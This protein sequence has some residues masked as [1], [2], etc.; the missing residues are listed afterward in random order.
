MVFRRKKWAYSSKSEPFE[1]GGNCLLQGPLGSMVS[2][3]LYCV[4]CGDT[5]VLLRDVDV[6]R[7]GHLRA[8][9]AIRVPWSAVESKWRGTN[10]EG[11]AL[12]LTLR[13]P[14]APHHD[15]LVFTDSGA[16]LDQW[17]AL[18]NTHGVSSAE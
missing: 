3:N 15:A 13:E 8:R 4:S 1:H 11:D 12:I 17:E 16:A 9:H 7:R 14:P 5:I 18:A 2:P 6:Y 10:G